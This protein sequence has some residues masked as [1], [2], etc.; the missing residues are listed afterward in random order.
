MR[1]ASMATSS[2]VASSGMTSARACGGQLVGEPIILFAEFVLRLELLVCAFLVLGV[3]PL[4]LQGIS[5]VTL[6]A[7]AA[8]APRRRR[9]APAPRA[10]PSHAR[11]GSA[12]AAPRPRP[13]RAC[14][15][16]GQAPEESRLRWS[17]RRL[18]RSPT[19]S[20]ASLLAFAPRLRTLSLATGATS[21]AWTWRCGWLAH[22][23]RLP[24]RAI[25][26][27]LRL[28]CVAIQAG[29]FIGN[30]TIQRGCRVALDAIFGQIIRLLRGKSTLTDCGAW[31]P[32]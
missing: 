10:R 30:D 3:L 12:L 13:H 21:A 1:S 22:A 25:D 4:I 8:R 23:V 16:D 29:A 28:R 17:F 26:R 18:L 15:Q 20:P 9:R 31:G 24:A 32:H 11:P 2:V 7:D 14:D 27:A 19:W 6:S 5:P